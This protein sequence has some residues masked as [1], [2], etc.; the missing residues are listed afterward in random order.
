MNLINDYSNHL[1]SRIKV[2]FPSIKPV[3]IKRI[4]FKIEHRKNDDIITNEMIEGY[5]AS[6]A[7]HVYTGYDEIMDSGMDKVNARKM[8]HNIVVEY[9]KMWKRPKPPWL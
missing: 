3:D 6:Q 7:R 1:S 8:V 9:M 4:I 2:M 5:T